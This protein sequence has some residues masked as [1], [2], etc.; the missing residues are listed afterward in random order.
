M[1]GKFNEIRNEKKIMKIDENNIN[2][3][4]TMK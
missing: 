3:S 1:N 2:T 4:K